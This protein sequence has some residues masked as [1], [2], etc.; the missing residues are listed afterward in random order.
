MGSSLLGTLRYLPGECKKE[1]PF[2]KFQSTLLSLLGPGSILSQSVVRE[3]EGHLIAS[4]VILPIWTNHCDLGGTGIE[5]SVVIG[6]PGLRTSA[7]GQSR[8]LE[9]ARWAEGL[10]GM[11]REM[12][13]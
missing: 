13:P 6:Q 2:P 7:G 5:Y 1:R 3:C 9:R 10:L 12:V 4:A 11:C 8:G